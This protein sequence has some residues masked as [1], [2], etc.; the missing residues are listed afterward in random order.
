MSFSVASTSILRQQP[1]TC[2][3]LVRRL[4]IV[5][6]APRRHRQSRLYSTSGSP[7]P[8]PQHTLAIIGGGL[9]GLSS[10]FYFLRALSPSARRAAKVVIFE[11]DE[12]VG[13][14]CRSVNIASKPD[15]KELDHEDGVKAKA[16]GASRRELVF[17]TGPRSIRPVGLSG[18]LTVEMVGLFRRLL[19]APS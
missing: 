5:S 17:E 14:W 7:A 8:P 3:F 19:A 4:R 13:G 10:A 11:K 15:V 16:R 1:C 9:S 6:S 18:W 2:S 12:R